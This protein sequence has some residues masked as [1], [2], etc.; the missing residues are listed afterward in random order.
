MNSGKVARL[1]SFPGFGAKKSPGF[2]QT[3]KLSPLEKVGQMDV[4]SFEEITFH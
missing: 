3:Q 1:F 2:E 4:I